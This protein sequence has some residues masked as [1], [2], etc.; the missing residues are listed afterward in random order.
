VGPDH[1]AGARPRP[2]AAVA[3]AVLA[4]LALVTTGL[5]VPAAPASATGPSAGP[6]AGPGSGSGTPVTG[7]GPMDQAVTSAQQAAADAARRV[8]ALRLEYLDRTQVAAAAAGRLA[9]AFAAQ[10]RLDGRHDADAAALARARAARST[11]IRAVY[12]D[13][14]RLGL[15]MSVL[16][17]G[18]ADDALWRLDTARRIEAGVLRS[19]DRQAV[20]A[21]GQESA[22][23]AEA[24]A[25]ATADADLAQAL[26]AVQ[27][28][29]AAADAVLQQARA[30]LDR[31]DARTRQLAAAR[32]AAQRLAQ[33]Q[34]QAEAARLAAGPVSALSIPVAYEAAYR[35]GAATCPG[36][37]WTLLAAVGQIESGH[38]RNNGPSSAGAIGPMQFMPAT[39][40][41][42][43]VDGDG[44]GVTDPWDYRDAIFTAAAYLC[45]SG[46]RGGTPDGIRQA[47]FAY[48]HA[49]W[50]VDLV[51][52]AQQAILSRPPT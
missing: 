10:A 34:A 49:Q 19:A 20:G 24:A 50:Y 42:Y 40:A 11:S 52:A 6:S 8:D 38:G 44:D 21:A 4:A 15:L 22:S 5:L 33:T 31:L 41:R 29:V 46:A 18:N 13:G 16:A 12:A 30:E 48:N 51:L 39:F 35:A 43:A 25:A 23:A 27:E 14:G 2:V 17:A 28:D 47:L 45:A 1:V 26:A 7:S 3:A 36:I 9:A 32:D 37:D